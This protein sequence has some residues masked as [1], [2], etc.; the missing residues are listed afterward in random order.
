MGGRETLRDVT[1]RGEAQ[2]KD[3]FSGATNL[4]QRCIAAGLMVRDTQ[5]EEP[6][7]YETELRSAR[8]LQWI[9]GIVA[10]LNARE[11]RH[12]MNDL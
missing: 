5:Q 1:R 4:F 3:S 2:A 7:A 12:L 9:L 11:R 8:R 10:R 6:D